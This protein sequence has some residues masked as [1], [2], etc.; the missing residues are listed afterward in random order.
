MKTL[1]LRLRGMKGELEELGEETEGVENISKMQGQILNMTKGKVNIFDDAGNF[2]S[3]YDIMKGIAEV[4]DDLSSTDQ[5]DLLETIAGKNRANDVAALIS[6]FD[7]AIKMVD[8][9]ENSFGSAAGENE[10]YLDSLQGRI[11]VMTA[12]LQAL[13]VS[14]LDSD[15]LKGGV[16]AITGFLD[17]LKTLIDTVGVLPT[18]LAAAGAGF[19]LFGKR[20]IN[21]G[22]DAETGNAKLQMFG[23][24]VG[25]IRDI[26]GAFVSNKG[27]RME[28]AL[29]TATGGKSQLDTWTE[30]FDVDEAAFNKL[31]VPYDPS[32]LNNYLEG[33]SEAF[34][35]WAQDVNN[36]GKTFADFKKQQGKDAINSITSNNSFK[37]FTSL[38]DEYNST[39]DSVDG[40]SKRFG[41]TQQEITDSINSTNS[42]AKNYIGNLNGTKASITGYTASLVGATVKT[43]ALEAASI[44]LQGVLTMGIGVAIG[45]VITLITDWINAEQK[46]AETVEEATSS[47]KQQ[48][49]ELSKGK[50][51]FEEAA[52]SY[53][54]LSKGVDKLTGKNKNLTTDEY[55]EYANAVNTIADMA[56]NLVAGYDA[57]GNAILDTT[58]KV[59]DLTQAYNDLIIAENNKYLNGDGENFEGFTSVIEDFQND[60]NN[61]TSFNGTL[62]SGASTGMAQWLDDLFGLETTDVD[63]IIDKFGGNTARLANGM[64]NIL[65]DNGITLDGFAQ[66][67]GILQKDEAAKYISEA[68]KQ[69]PNEFKNIVNELN[70][71]IESSADET[72]LSMQRYLEN[73]FLSGDYENISKQT[74]SIM[75]SVI[76]NLDAEF[77]DSIIGDKTGS[78][79]E[80]A[81]NTWVDNLLATFDGMDVGVKE[82]LESAFN[83]QNLFESGEISLGE[84]QKKLKDV[85]ATIDG[86]N[87]D[88]EVKQE[89]KLSL[90]IDD[91]QEQYDTLINRITKN[92][93]LD[94]KAVKN[95]VDDISSEDFNILMSMELDGIDTIDEL[96]EALDLARVI[97]G[98]LIEIN[99][100]ADTQT[101]TNLNDAMAASRTAAGLTT[102]QIEN[103]NN[104][105][106]DLDGYSAA[107][108]FEET[109]N[110]IRL[111]TQEYEKFS[112]ELT[113]GKLREAS[114][115]LQTYREGLDVLDDKIQEARMSGAENIDELISQ[116][117]QL[118]QNITATAQYASQ[119]Q[120]LTSAYKEWQ[121]AES[122]GSDRDM[123]ESVLSGF[124]SIED[125]I[126]RGWLDDASK[127]FIELLSFDGES[128]S[129]IDDY[130]NRWNQLGQAIDGTTYSVRDF[131]TVNEDGESTN[132]GVYNFLDAVDQL[133]DERFKI[134]RDENG[135]ITSFDFGVNGDAA[136][137]EALGVSEELVNI[138]LRASEDAGFVI[139]L[140]GAYTQLADLQEAAK[141][142][143]IDLKEIGKTDMEFTLDTSDSEKFV[144][145]MD[146]A[147][148]IWESYRNEDGT[149]NWNLDGAEEAVTLYSTLVAQA[150]KLSDPVYMQLDTSQVETELQEPLTKMQEFDSLLAR[151]HQIEINGGDVS[152]VSYEM[153]KIVDYLHNL[154]GETKVKLGIEGMSKEEIE[155]GL[156]QG[157]I[158][159]P[160]TVDLQVEMSENIEDIRMALLKL[161][162]AI[163][164]EEYQ[165]YIDAR[166]N[167]EMEVRDDIENIKND[168]Y[169]A[170]EALNNLSDTK[171]DFNFDTADMA[172]L[173]GQIDKAKEL[174]DQF[175]KEDGTVDL[176]VEGAAQAQQILAALLRQKEELDP[177][178]IMK[179]EVED[180]TSDVG[181]AMTAV[182]QLYSAVQERNINI[183]I[184]A[185]TTEVDGQISRLVT[186]LA[187]LQ[188]NNPELY[189]NLGLNTADFNNALSTLSANIQA[190]VELDPNALSIVQSS[191]KGIDV[192]VLAKIAGLD[193]SMVDEYVAPDKEATT[194]Y[195]VNSS[196]VDRWKAPNK[197]GTA[198]YKPQLS[199]TKLPTLHGTANY[200]VTMSGSSPLRGHV[201]GQATKVNGTA[202]VNGT[203]FAHGD[204]STKDSGVALVGE[205]GRETVVRNGKFFTIGDNGAEFFNYKKGDIIFNHK[206]TEELFKNGYV[207]SNGGRGRAYAQG[208]AFSSGSG[209]LGPVGGKPVGNGTVINN[210]TNNYNYNTSKS[211]SSSSKK[212]SSSAKK[213]AD[214]FKESLDWIEIAIDRVERAIDSLD[215]TATNTFLDFAERDGALLQQ[216]Q[217]V[218]NEINLQQ[219]AYERYMAEANSVGLSADWQDKVKNGRIDI[220][221]I[222]DEGLKEQIDQFQEWY[223]KALDAKDALDDLNITISELNKQRWDTLI[224]EFDLYLNRIQNSGDMIE[225]IVN[226][227][228]VDG[229]IISK[230]Y[231]TELQNNAHAEAEMLREERERLIAL[232]DEMVNNGSMEVLSDEWYAMNNQI[233]EIT[234][235]IYECQT[236]WAEYQKEIRETE[237]KVFDLLQERISGVA[238]EAQFLID[239][240]SN[241]KLFEDNGQLTD[242]GWATMGLYGQQYNVFMNQADRYAEE[243]KKLEDQMKND[244]YLT[245]LTGDGHDNL[246]IVD[247]YY[248]LIEAQQEAI[249][250]AEQ[251]KDAMKDM[252]EEGIEL[253]LDALDE[254]ID[255]YLDALQAQKDLYDY[256][257]DISERTENIAALEKQLS[258]FRGDDSE[259]SRA[260]IQE[261]TAELEDARKELADAEYER[262]I[263]DVERL[264]DQMR[265]DYETVLNARLD[266]IDALIMDMIAEINANAGSI[267]ETISAEASN[268]GYTLSDEMQNIW[269][270]AN[271]VLA[272]YGDQ[273]LSNG[274]TVATTL[275]SIN[276][277]IQNMISRL[278][279]I[280]Q[281]R[282]E[283]AKKQQADNIPVTKPTP[284]PSPA[285]APAP[286][287]QP[288]PP[289]Q[290]T[291]GGMIN[292]GGARIYADS[293]GHGGGRQYFANDPVY[294]VLQKRNGYILTRWHGLSSGYTGWFRESDVSALAKGKRLIDEDQ[295]AWTQENGAE[296]IVRPS[297]GAILTPLAKNDS[298]LN[299]AATQ[300]IWDMANNPS[301][302]VRDN[303]GIGGSSVSPAT[304][305]GNTNY[306][307]DIQN[308]T[309]NFPNVK[310]YEELLASMQK[311]RNFERLINSMTLD[312]IAGKNSLSK[313]KA[314]R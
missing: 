90:N 100:E 175:R 249:L 210:T 110:G 150:D 307:Q 58:G 61:L 276:T 164:E 273:F 144:A 16:S 8:T 93:S 255:K 202:H 264:L 148:K 244:P 41:M 97:N 272:M 138:I 115:A 54:K 213:A 5:A 281:Q 125:E 188:Q 278:D 143:A 187:A 246:D 49:D 137:A 304:T 174:L 270:G 250:S 201:Y 134:E 6:N 172:D 285:P 214:E 106:A 105:F 107:K 180:P 266:N 259:E 98:T 116:R 225:E 112:E 35:K 65:K 27:S 279:A 189:A 308:V 94:S 135:I 39:L 69:Y 233:D 102:E 302:F 232:R 71:S 191:L 269:N 256:S 114:D 301:A 7:T 68:M 181:R 292:A 20:F 291:V 234:V 109:A 267:S 239:L 247:R 29:N 12:S 59:E 118:R 11:D 205:L 263:S 157:T 136:V 124:E 133:N 179:V 15:F 88:E 45:A 60:M 120:G 227:A 155:A 103:V 261:I 243:I 23:K 254:L 119:L 251:M 238:D 149:I 287:P 99:I 14:T 46:L 314:I 131:F 101:I 160:A 123:Y 195:D 271:N 223:E 24:S 108:M 104:A 37:N 66:S 56:P 194:I 265:L 289:K 22:Q 47:Y 50:A 217:Q 126:S 147:K 165:L 282:I 25:E 312:K 132:Q 303:L 38:I 184:G 32:E 293:E 204:W 231:Y 310:N 185:D 262:Q 34:R 63:S 151:K 296:M 117:E 192:D 253:E 288:E 309:F 169:D 53:E 161:T 130:I 219:Q 44:A 156:E 121:D 43:F 74:Q 222:T 252:V 237:W 173:Y 294:V 36:A 220:E 95:F 48:H 215:K 228:E 77:I 190:G 142:A 176:S 300:N 166:L 64:V 128:F 72:R 67:F 283:E 76:G 80:A 28:S 171:Y 40:T 209:G 18:V 3:T 245:G 208:T 284:S 183:A 268:V 236:A 62:A 13:S 182:Q 275:S 162:G 129:S 163:S 31:T 17:V 258:A 305:A 33:T 230:N 70:D 154:D 140:D 226:R 1:S 30:M 248:E 10:K 241:E 198:F 85:E 113:N 229:Q 84:Y 82:K 4:Y 91:V 306:N 290:V 167:G 21:I 313:N 145:E 127:E 286:A 89:I 224:D 242:K 280:A 206:Q 42:V 152:K 158:E 260:Q 297:D 199:T 203:A 295:L 211:T 78:E 111:N 51:S 87:L 299:A 55:E 52:Q 240:M 146:E 193:T 216:M 168:A 96:R 57:Q 200:T 26:I 197:N 122:A 73:A 83:M 9:A 274:T 2:K 207:T 79:A 298:V 81:L 75:D 277:G 86:L 218:T 221:V 139:N 92:T 141:Q 235:S 170:Q 311:D 19:S 257:S 212:S 186:Q 177:P 196:K 159:I 178:A 153:D